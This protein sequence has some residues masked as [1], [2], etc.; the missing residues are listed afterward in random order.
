MLL[1]Y[2][3]ELNRPIYAWQLTTTR[4][5]IYTQVGVE[6][7]LFINDS[8]LAKLRDSL[9]N[10]IYEQVYSPFLSSVESKPSEEE[11]EAPLTARYRGEG[12]EAPLTAPVADKLDILEDDTCAV[13]LSILDIMR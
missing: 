12:R 8:W 6:L 2:A 1:R 5:Y 3:T 9:L 13:E 4:S 7:R 10:D 11:D